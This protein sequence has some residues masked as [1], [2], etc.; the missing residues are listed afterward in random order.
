[1]ETFDGQKPGSIYIFFS[2]RQIYHCLQR[3]IDDNPQVVKESKQNYLQGAID[4]L[5]AGQKI[6][7]AMQRVVGV[8]LE[9]SK[10]K[11]QLINLYLL[12]SKNSATLRASTLVASIIILLP[13]V[14]SII[15]LSGIAANLPSSNLVL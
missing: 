4:K 14:I 15:T 1:M 5:V 2:W 6:E 10:E 9:G 11:N 7:P 12:Q 3:A 8:R 13:S